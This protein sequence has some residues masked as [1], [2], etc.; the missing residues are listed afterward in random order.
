MHQ[1]G[2]HGARALR[3]P[4]LALL[5][6]QPDRS[7]QQRALQDPQGAGLSLGLL[8]PPRALPPR[9]HAGA[10]GGGVRGSGRLGAGRAGHEGERLGLPARPEG[11]DP[12]H[13]RALRRPREVAGDRPLEVGA[14]GAHQHPRDEDG[15][16]GGGQ[17]GSV[18]GQLGPPAPVLR[19]LAGHPWLLPEGA[20]KPPDAALPLP[21]DGELGHRLRPASLLAVGAYPPQ[22]R[23][24]AFARLR[25]R[26]RSGD[27]GEGGQAARARRA[28]RELL[29][30]Q[31][32]APPR[33]R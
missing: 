23:R 22:S 13:Q 31:W 18:K 2:R 6:P 8:P 12:A 17:A 15:V 5:A 27:S 32:V 26:R 21:K 7:G 25:N 28:A 3:H 24:R 30:G 29:E 33:P 20:A 14:G 19:G 4:V 9:V 16:D 10:R 1:R 11:E